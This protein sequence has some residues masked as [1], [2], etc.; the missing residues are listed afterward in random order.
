MNDCEMPCD[1]EPIRTIA[2]RV[3]PE[4]IAEIRQTQH[5]DSDRMRGKTDW[6]RECQESGRLNKQ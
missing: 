6:D 1:L 5:I 3:F 4:E 2:E